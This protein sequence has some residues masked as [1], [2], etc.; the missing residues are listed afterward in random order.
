MTSPPLT[1]IRA[2]CDAASSEFPALDSSV[3]FRYLADV[4]RW[5]ERVPLVSRRS[6]LEVLERLV[7]QSVRLYWLAGKYISP[8]SAIRRLSVVDIGSGAGFPGLIWKLL[9]P[10]IR[11]TL[12][13]RKT[14]KVTFLRRTTVAL[15]LDE[16]EIV[17]GDAVECGG[18]DRFRGAF[19]I[20]T[21]FA[22]GPLGE[23][24][25]VVGRFLRDDGL[26]LTSRPR[27]ED[28]PPE[29]DGGALRLQASEQSEHGALVAYRKIGR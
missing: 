15:G 21:T 18:R 5:N 25:A 24:S 4:V 9:D 29:L 16:T 20:A 22:V 11:L 6:T 19:E 26:Y 2:L 3:L 28:L 10:G 14:K 17:E 12:V 8:S 13:E 27:L 23:M 7:G 1:R